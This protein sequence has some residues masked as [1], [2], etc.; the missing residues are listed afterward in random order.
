MP[1][2]SDMFASLILVSALICGCGGGSS[3]NSGG[4]GT[5]PPAES[6][7]TPTITASPSQNGATIATRTDGTNGATIYYTVDGSNPTSTSMQYF[8]PFLVASNLTVKAI[9]AAPGYSN[10]KVAS[11]DFAPNLASGVL[12]WSDEF[13][14]SGTA[15]ALPDSKIWT[16]DT[17]FQNCGNNEKET[18]CAAGSTTSPCD[19]SN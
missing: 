3:A 19:P 15:N 1:M 11:K 4:D 5:P 14:N 8:A 13:P 10:S 9:A 18:Y 17:G 7:A 12:V 6:A 2:R 16:Y